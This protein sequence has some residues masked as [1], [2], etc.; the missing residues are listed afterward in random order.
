MKNNI[1]KIILS[2]VSLLS[3]VF[4][5]YFC[6]H[7]ESP[8]TATATMWL[9]FSI[10]SFAFGWPEVAKSIKFFGSGVDLGEVE[11]SLK[12]MRSVIEADT[13]ALLE[14]VQTQMRFGGIPD[15]MKEKIYEDLAS[16]LSDS[17]FSPE[18]VK[19]IQERWH[20]WITGDYVRGI[21]VV[22]KLSHP[23]IPSEKKEEWMEKREDLKSRINEITPQE[24][25]DV[26]KEFNGYNDEVKGLIEDFDYY[27]KNLSHKRPDIWENREHW[28]G[29]H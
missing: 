11:T 17:G 19:N 28:F 23:A 26:F 13:R 7:P 6:F 27:K 29:G 5:A 9:T 18:E 21:I 14:L 20:F 16:V 22:N 15:D 2:C 1:R 8:D 25:I 10:L 4:G 24:L 12:D 3:L